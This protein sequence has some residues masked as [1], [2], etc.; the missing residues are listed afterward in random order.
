MDIILFSVSLLIQFIDPF[1]GIVALLDWIGSWRRLRPS[2]NLSEYW[3]LSFFY[4]AFDRL[5]KA[6]LG[7]NLLF[8]L[9]FYLFSLEYTMLPLE[10][11]WPLY[12]SKR[13]FFKWCYLSFLKKDSLDELPDRLLNKMA[14]WFS[15][16]FSILFGFSSSLLGR[17]IFPLM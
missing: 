5:L 15:T 8:D 9:R 1:D 7:T 4:A 6:R 17:F 16:V 11:F 10:L 3:F 2:R 13:D 14:R 12:Y